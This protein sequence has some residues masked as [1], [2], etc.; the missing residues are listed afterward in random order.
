[1][2]PVPD[3]PPSPLLILRMCRQDLLDLA[4]MPLEAVFIG[5]RLF[6]SSW[7]QL[8]DQGLQ[9]LEPDNFIFLGH[10]ESM[11]MP[12]TTFSIQ[13]LYCFSIN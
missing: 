8:L 3:R 7:M 10:L 4:Y 9:F 2:L 1:M 12:T 5:N 6:N 11:A 13:R